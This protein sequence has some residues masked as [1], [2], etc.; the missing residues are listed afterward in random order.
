LRGAVEHRRGAAA[1]GLSFTAEYLDRREFQNSGEIIMKHSAK[2]AL[3]A[4]GIFSVMGPTG[5]HAVVMDFNG[6]V[7]DVGDLLPP[8][9]EDIVNRGN[10]YVEDGFQLESVP[11]TA[12]F[13][14]YHSPNPAFTGSVSF[15]NFTSLGP[16]RLTKI[17][18]GGFDLD[19]IDLDTFA[20]N[21]SSSVTFIG[22]LGDLST[23]SQ[24]FNISAAPIPGMQTFAF[25]ALFDNVIQVDWMQNAPFHH[26]D[27]I[28]L[29]GGVT[30]GGCARG[31]DVCDTPA[32]VPEPV[33]LS[34]LGAG[35]LGIGA[36]RRRRA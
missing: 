2:L 10:L 35:L 5:A 17:G 6:L 27:N 7:A 13:L 34:L 16:T 24:L 9:G 23:E 20:L 4:I 11:G 29:D 31:N 21:A 32:N 12:S 18:G 30:G 3:A 26:F 36:A 19:S 14:S 33:T 1:Q 8:I 22:T 28:V 15:T 25:S